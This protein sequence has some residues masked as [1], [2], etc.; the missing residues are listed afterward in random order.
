MK[1][2]W[3]KL[4]LAASL[5]LLVSGCMDADV[6]FEVKA[7]GSGSMDMVVD[8]D[9]A[10]FSEMFSMF[11]PSATASPR[12]VCDE[13][14]ADTGT[15]L[16]QGASV[17][18]VND[19]E[20]CAVMLAASWPAGGFE[21]SEMFGAEDSP[22]RLTEPTPGQW[23]F[24]FTAQELLAGSDLEGAGEEM[25]QEWLAMFPMDMTLTVSVELPGQVTDHNGT[26]TDSKVSWEFN[27]LEPAPDGQFFAASSPGGGSS[28]AAPLLVG[29]TAAGVVMVVGVLWWRGRRS[30]VSSPASGGMSTVQ[31]GSGAGVAA[32]SAPMGLVPPPP[33]TQA[34]WL[35]DPTGSGLLR[36]WDGA[37]W[38][39]W[40]SVRPSQ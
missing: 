22:F 26:V 14:L 17:T 31:E 23:R 39:E 29:L 9:V 4:L 30:P 7:D 8:F 2:M 18:T 12:E 10:A 16:P 15:D 38:T 33:G 32:G 20:R 34:G 13:L 37:K 28:S 40:T 6:A 1:S 35:E 21:V 24:E 27:L 5:P 25:P 3:A 19:G 11:D 36:W